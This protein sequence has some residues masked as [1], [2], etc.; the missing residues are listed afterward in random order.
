M[1]GA[2][3]GRSEDQ[4]WPRR[5]D[6]PLGPRL[7]SD[8][9]YILCHLGRD[10]SAAV[11]VNRSAHMDARWRLSAPQYAGCRDWRRYLLPTLL[12]AG[13]PVDAALHQPPAWLPL[14][15]WRLGRASGTVCAAA[16]RADEL[17]PR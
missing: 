2:L 5:A 3:P 13:Q 1:E 4:Q 6:Q 17:A 12:P 8:W 10:Q 15:P 16:A 11:Q 7:F 9:R 14:L